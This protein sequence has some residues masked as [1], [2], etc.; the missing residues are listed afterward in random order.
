M[1]DSHWPFIYTDFRGCEKTVVRNDGQK[2]RVAIRG[3]EFEGSDFDG[4]EPLHDIGVRASEFTLLDGRDLCDCRM[5]CEIPMV[6]VQDGID[7]QAILYMR[8]VLGKPAPRPR[9]GIDAE[10]LVLELAFDG[11]R[12]MSR[13]ISEG[14]FEDELQDIQKALLPDA[15]LKCCFGCGLSDYSPYGHGLF[16][17]M[18]CYRSCK[19]AYRKVTSKLQIWPI[20]GQ[21]ESV[22]ETWLC[23][24]FERRKPGTGYR[25]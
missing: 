13:G 25:G 17:C 6:V 4:F 16:G 19:E 10:D 5:E 2:L 18:Q 1:P 15:Y 11:K 14:W 9:G 12:F 3:V 20:M 22:Q 21:S 24:E 23:E 7:L 8:L